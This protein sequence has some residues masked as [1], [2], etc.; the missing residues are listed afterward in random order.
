MFGAPFHLIPVMVLVLVV[1]TAAH[2]TERE[3][4]KI[5]KTTEISTKK[6]I[7]PLTRGIVTGNGATPWCAVMGIGTP[8]QSIRCMIDT[9]GELCG[10]CQGQTGKSQQYTTL[11]QTTPHS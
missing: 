11:T 2:G 4:P 5:P 1:A 7:L 10:T 6:V 9:G 8:A 3:F